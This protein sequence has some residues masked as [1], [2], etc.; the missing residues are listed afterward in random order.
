MEVILGIDPGSNHMG[1]ALLERRNKSLRTLATG[2]LSLKKSSGHFERLS[3]IFSTVEELIHC[4]KPALMAV[5]APFYGKSIQSMLKLGRAQ[6]AAIAAALH[7]GIPVSEYAPRRI[8][9]AVTGRG[10]AS[11]EQV[12]AMLRQMHLLPDDEKRLDASDALA[13]AFCHATRRRAPHEQTAPV[14]TKKSKSR[15]SRSNAWS[16]FLRKNPDRLKGA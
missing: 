16:D 10:A 14:L 3:L 12:Q 13:V 6:G 5:E 7:C 4:Y 8:K 9:Q 11:K 1:Y 2:V 15:K